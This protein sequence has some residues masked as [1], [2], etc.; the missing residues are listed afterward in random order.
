MG[1]CN[2]ILSPEMTLKL[3]AGGVLSPDGISY[4]FDHRA[5]GYSRGEGFGAIILKRVSD[6]IRD[7]DTIRA[8]IRST[9]VNQD[10]KSPGLTQPTQEAQ[11]DLIRSVYSRASLDL[12]LT[13]FFEAHGT[14]TI[15]GDSIEASAISE[16]FTPHRSP[17]SPLYVGA[18]KSNVGHLEGAAG[19]ASIIKGVLTL[20][21]GI[22]PANAWFEKPNPKISNSWYL[23]FPSRAVCW[24]Q[25]GLRRMSL[26]SFGI[27]GTNAHM[28]L[29]DAYHYLKQHHLTGIHRTIPSPDP[30][31]IPIS[32]NSTEGMIL[33]VTCCRLD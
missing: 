33:L 32:G 20:E 13:R 1:G 6:A 10:G 23:E 12:S 9:G 11:A 5:N 15:I 25:H 3:D 7:G 30:E 18:L 8:I 22:I 14:G 24:P 16:I 21:K 28:V 4:S 19:V 29:D 2:L 17:E 27:G 31:A 26:N